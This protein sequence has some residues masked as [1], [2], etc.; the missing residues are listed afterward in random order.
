MSL[1]LVS[2]WLKFCT[3]SIKKKFSLFS[4][5]WILRIVISKRKSNSPNSRRQYTCPE[6]KVLVQLEPDY[7]RI[8][9]S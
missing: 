1:V 8:A 7:E 4:I 6:M 9:G 5:I 2:K 3:V